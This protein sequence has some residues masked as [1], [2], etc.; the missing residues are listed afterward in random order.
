MVLGVYTLMHIFQHIFHGHYLVPKCVC[1]AVLLLR[2]LSTAQGGVPGLQLG[3]RQDH[4]W[5]D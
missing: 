4:T 2:T 3:S 1:P 5:E